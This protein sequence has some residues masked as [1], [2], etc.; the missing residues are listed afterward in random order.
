[1][2]QRLSAGRK[3]RLRQA[4]PYLLVVL[5]VLV[6]VWR[7][8]AVP[9]GFNQDEAFAGYEA[10][11]LLH[12]GIDAD[13][14]PNPVYLTAWGS[15]MNALQSW[16]MMP[17]AALFGLTETAARLPQLLLGCATLPVFYCLL[18]D[19]LGRRTALVGLALLA[20]SPWHIMLSR[21]ALESNLAPF[22]LITG[23]WLLLKGLREPRWW[24]AA[25]AVYGIGL[26]SY[27]LTWV[28][29][30]LT[31]I[32]FAVCLPV[33]RPQA[34][35]SRWLWISVGILFVLA[36]PLILFYLVNHDLL[37]E[38]VT[39]FLSIPHMPAFR[40]SELSLQNLFRAQT[41]QNL[42]TLYIK[43][44]DGLLWNT[45]RF[46][47]FYHW[48]VPFLFIGAGRML[49]R[50][51]QALRSRRMPVELLLLLPLAAGLF[52]G[53]LTERPNTNRT[54]CVP[55]FLLLL[56][57]AGIE[58]L[59]LA[60][61]R[62]SSLLPALAGIAAVVSLSAFVWY[63]FREYDQALSWTFQKG[64]RDA[65]AYIQA[66]DFEDVWVSPSVSYSKILFYERVPTPQYLE[67]V[68]YRDPQ[69]AFRAV[70]SFT[71]FTFGN[72]E[73]PGAHDA[74]LV[75]NGEI[76]TYF[77]QGTE[78]CTINYFDTVAVVLPP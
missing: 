42:Y 51:W 52:A 44:N 54:N 46:G 47:L 36:L 20:V 9:S 39:P 16:L 35:R 69:S 12:Y 27:A 65:V 74:Y 71:R 64:V 10:W 24:M 43:Q 13:G 38:I 56:I 5:G 25:A 61:G 34:F 62:W 67:T 63:Y 76:S 33:F 15:G 3:Q 60:P 30:P 14:Y 78:S 28:V 58:A 40:D 1:M 31:L 22:F 66:N 19:T 6:R 8:G 49:R 21:W 7:F 48:T 18:R 26:Y 23:Y 4:L 32:L 72:G 70:D 53:M 17:F 59:F 68:R 2:T 45:T 73:T 57:A 75:P 55:L 41:W 77:A 11:S 37:P 50:I 29:V